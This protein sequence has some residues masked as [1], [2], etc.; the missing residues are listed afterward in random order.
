MT[1][2]QGNLL[3][4]W[5]LLLFTSTMLILG[6]VYWKYTT[7]VIV[8]PAVVGTLVLL[9]AGWLI[10]RCSTASEGELEKE[11]QPF[12]QGDH[13]CSL[14]KRVLWLGS[15]FPLGYLFGFV[16]GLIALTLAYTSYHGLPW[17]QRVLTS[18][19]VFSFVYIGFY[20]VLGVPLPID[21]VWLRE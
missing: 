2:R 11:C 8:F 10:F 3:I 12:E 18:A 13:R 17:W 20:K 1:S 16:I 21:P 4:A 9:C 7:K 5:L 15:V 14:S 19:T 6:A